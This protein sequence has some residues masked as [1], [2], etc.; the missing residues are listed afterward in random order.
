MV[1]IGVPLKKKHNQ[2]HLTFCAGKG[3]PSSFPTSGSGKTILS[4]TPSPAQA[5]QKG[6]GT[7]DELSLPRTTFGHDFSSEPAD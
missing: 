4:Q 6:S 1:E 7:P 3:K 5:L 2:A